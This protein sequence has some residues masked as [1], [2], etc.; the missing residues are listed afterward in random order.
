MDELTVSRKDLCRGCETPLFESYLQR[1]EMEGEFTRLALP[2][3]AQ[4][5]YAGHGIEVEVLCLTCGNLTP[6]YWAEFGISWLYN[7][8]GTKKK[9][10]TDPDPSPRGRYEKHLEDTK[11]P[12][13]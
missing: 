7:R 3:R 2:K 11:E 4:M 13:G 5:V 10:P 6:L 9:H 1:A 12:S 8:D